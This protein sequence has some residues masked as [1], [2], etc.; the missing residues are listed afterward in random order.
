MKIKVCGLT[1]PKEAAYLNKN[2]VDFAGFVLFF[3][4]S[5]RN[6]T[7]TQ[8][9]EIRPMVAPNNIYREKESLSCNRKAKNH[10]PRQSVTAK[11]SCRY[12]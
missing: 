11:C 4:K 12:S 7:I 8:A 5:K 9:T 10:S 1:N 3:P 2:H 6:I